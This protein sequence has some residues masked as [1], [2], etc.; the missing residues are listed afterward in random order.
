MSEPV[1]LYNPDT[2]ARS[3][4]LPTIAEYKGNLIFRPMP[5]F[6]H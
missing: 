5:I 3:L 1:E 4:K 6:A 2:V